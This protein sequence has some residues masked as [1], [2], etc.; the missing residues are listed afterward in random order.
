MPDIKL[1]DLND[2]EIAHPGTFQAQ[3]GKV[4]LT[5]NTLKDFVKNFDDGVYVPYL[6]LDHDDKLTDRVRD[7]LKVSR[8]G[9]VNKLWKAGEKLMANFTGVPKGI[10]DFIK[11]GAMNLRS[12]EYRKKWI[13]SA[14][15]IKDNVLE[16]VTFFGK[17]KPAIDLEPYIPVLYNDNPIEQDGE[18]ISVNLKEEVSKMPKIEVEEQEYKDMLK[19]ISQTEKLKADAEASD[20]KIERLEGEKKTLK[21]NEDVATK[22][23]EDAEKLQDDI[24]KA[25]ESDAKTEAEAYADSII[26]A[27]KKEPKYKEMIVKNIIR[28]QGEENTD[29]LKLY[30][31]DLESAN[32]IKLGGTITDDSGDGDGKT[33]LKAPD[34]ERRGDDGEEYLKVA[35]KKFYADADKK[36][37][38]KLKADKLDM[39]SENYVKTAES[40]GLG[41]GGA[42]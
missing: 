5:E 9:S 7:A 11:N 15:K 40:L 3:T 4:T 24:V 6:N 18:V 21:D 32:E 25:K 27:K 1:V 10:A 41:D 42:A 28:L 37:K 34:F 12:A 35:E 33:E 26:L 29:E 17:G 38:A 19:Q 39:T 22:M 8:L 2:V 36:I 16:A 20:T 23:K 13:M 14:D 30:K 31:E